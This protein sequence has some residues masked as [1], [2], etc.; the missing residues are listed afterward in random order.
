MMIDL[1]QGDCLELL[2][3]IPDGS[4]DL[5]LTDPPYGTVKDAPKNWTVNNGKAHEWDST[6]DNNKMWH[7][8][9][10]VL[11][12]NGA[13]L[14]FAQQPYT[15]ALINECHNNTPF[16][17]CLTWIK[18]NFANALGCNKAPV[19][20]T[21]DVCVFFK[22]HDFL[23]LHPLRLYF[24]EIL[25]FIGLK[26][27]QINKKLGCR[28]AEHCFYVTPKKAVLGEVGGKADHVTKVGSS[29]FSLCTEQTYNDL[30][31][32]FGIDEMQGFRVY[33]ELKKDDDAHKKS[34]ARVFNLHDGKKYKSNILEYKKDY[35]GYH[36]T[37]KPVLLLEDLIKTYTNEGET[38]LD[39]TAGSMST[40][41]A[42]INTNRK[43]IM[44]EKDS[45]YFKVGSERVEKALSE[46]VINQNT[47]HLT[48]MV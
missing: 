22:K 14:L 45:H 39:F 9:N 26:L 31:D 8:I 5:I 15:T 40:A 17:Y 13:C 43:G 27:P 2:K 25:D 28:R 19:N 42:C 3:D 10:R 23:A 12:V 16:S 20:Y 38:V 11:R 36:P 34:I 33:S 48:F 37:Q 21:E 4:V 1:R 6:I 41:I 44:I 7:E 32:I 18:D 47:L 35:N 24:K 30:I 29:Q 46:K